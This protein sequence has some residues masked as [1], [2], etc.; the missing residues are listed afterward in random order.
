M[1]GMTS[2]IIGNSNVEHCVKA[3]KKGNIS[4]P[5][6]WTM[7]LEFT[8][9]RAFPWSGPVILK[10]CLCHWGKGN[11]PKLYPS[12]HVLVYTANGGESGERPGMNFHSISLPLARVLNDNLSASMMTCKC[13]LLNMITKTKPMKYLSHP[14]DCK[15]LTTTLN[16]T[17]QSLLRSNLK[18]YSR[19]ELPKY[20]ASALHPI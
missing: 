3:N 9:H 13:I 16:K 6:Y 14:I 1:S 2:N 17:L 12:A 7:W 4:A 19:L 5:Y 15:H 11:T 18:Q 8:G 10:V 20:H